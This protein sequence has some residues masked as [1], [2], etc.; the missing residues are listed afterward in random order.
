MKANHWTKTLL[1]MGLSAILATSCQGLQKGK[2][3]AS[4]S[5]AQAMGPAATLPTSLH[6]TAN[7]MKWWYEQ[8]DGFG[9]YCGVAYEK[10]GC[11]HCHTSSC[12]QCHQDAAGKKPAAQPE[13]CKHCHGRQKME[14]KLKLSDIHLEAGMQCSECHNSA[15]IHGD[16][17]HYDT[18]FS[19]GAMHVTCESCHSDQPSN[20]EHKQHGQQ[21]ACDACHLDSVITCYNCHFET[22]I[23]RHKKK[24][25]GALSGYIILL[26]DDRGRVRAGTYQTVVYEGKTFVAFGPY[27]GHTIKRKGRTC[28]DCHQN[29]RMLELKNSGKIVMTRWDPASKKVQHTTGVIPFVPDKFEFQFV[30][31]GPQGWAPLTKKTGRSQYRF[32][33]PLNKKQ[34]Q[35]L[36]AIAK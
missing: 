3:T 23:K 28:K 34:L 21:F 33:S 15:E 19:P 5:K 30:D 13:A 12:D 9:P 35:A 26:N 17:N 7:G 11:G 25:A 14:A 22:L 29:K 36:G 20:A 10:A 16:G 8:H 1:A 6:G 2:N 32:C 4:A 31:F 24:A 18:M 27:H